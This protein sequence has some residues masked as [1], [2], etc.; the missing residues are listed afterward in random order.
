MNGSA[1]KARDITLRYRSFAA[2]REYSPTP[3]QLPCYQACQF[4]GN[5]AKSVSNNA[6][7]FVADDSRLSLPLRHSWTVSLASIGH[8][9]HLTLLGAA[10]T[11]GRAAEEASMSTSSG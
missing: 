1:E 5:T 4:F 9:A 3:R 2:P 11:L 8:V 6:G 10:H 7:C